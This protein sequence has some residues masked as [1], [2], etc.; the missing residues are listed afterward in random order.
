M[1]SEDRKPSKRV[2]PLLQNLDLDNV[3]FAQVQ[4]VGDSIT[5]EDMNEQELQDLVLVNLA[6]LV[7][8]GEW[9]GLLE[10]GGGGEAIGTYAAIIPPMADGDVASYQ[11]PLPIANNHTEVT[12]WSYSTSNT[13][14]QFWPWTVQVSG[15]MD[16]LGVRVG[17]I[18]GTDLYIGFYDSDSDDFYPSGAPLFT[19][20]VSTTTNTNFVIDASSLG[21]VTAGD[22]LWLAI[23]G[24]S[25]KSKLNSAF[26]T[27]ITCAV[28]KIDSALETVVH[29][30]AIRLDGETAN[31][32]PTITASKE[33]E[34]VDLAYIPLLSFSVS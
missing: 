3:T 29:Q 2:F 20:T 30:C 21:A 22:V 1:R 4:G 13:V 5:I 8:S 26:T 28:P 11:L 6:R 25:T 33:F 10:A 32:F 24:Q 31:T 19:T 12:G 18:A 17:S 15:T 9:T 27:D 7:V 14:L 34:P 16:E 23:F